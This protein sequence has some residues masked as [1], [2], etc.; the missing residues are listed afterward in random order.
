MRDHAETDTSLGSSVFIA[1]DIAD[2][3]GLR[4]W[5][6]PTVRRY[7]TGTLQIGAAIGPDFQV[8]PPRQRDWTTHGH[9]PNSC[10]REVRN[11]WDPSERFFKQSVSWKQETTH[12][13]ET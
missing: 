7:D 9:C 6:S 3:S 10:L 13:K 1:T 8:V 5:V 11:A 4:L 2:D 12:A